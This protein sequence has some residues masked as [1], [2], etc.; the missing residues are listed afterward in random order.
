MRQSEDRQQFVPGKHYLSPLTKVSQD[1]VDLFFSHLDERDLPQ[2][3]R[4]FSD[5]MWKIEQHLGIKRA[6]PGTFLIDR[7]A[8]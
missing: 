8:K 1:T 4:D 2:H 6:G 5:L 3:W 7:G